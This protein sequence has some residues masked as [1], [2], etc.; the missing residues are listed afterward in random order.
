MPGSDRPATPEMPDEPPPFLG[1]WRN[2]YIFVLV[3]E[4][5]VIASFYLFT[6]AVA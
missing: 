5:L 6:R 1:K 2:V 4:A 3:Y